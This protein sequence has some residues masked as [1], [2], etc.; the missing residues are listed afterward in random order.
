MGIL[1]KNFG[2]LQ[3]RIKERA[4][5]KGTIFKKDKNEVS[6]EVGNTYKFRL[7]MRAED[8]DSKW[9]W[10]EDLYT[11]EGFIRRLYH[12]AKTPK[13]T[14]KYMQVNC[15]VTYH[16]ARGYKMCPACG[17]LQ[18]LW[19]NDRASYHKFKRK[20]QVYVYVYVLKDPVNPENEGHVKYIYLPVSLYKT[21]RLQIWGLQNPKKDEEPV[22]ID[23]ENLY[24]FDAFKLEK[25]FNLSIQIAEETIEDLQNEGKKKKVRKYTPLWANSRTSVKNVDMTELETEMEA[26]ELGKDFGPATK[27]E[28]QKFYNDVVLGFTPSEKTETSTETTKETKSE[29]KSKDFEVGGDG[30]DLDMG[31]KKESSVAEQVVDEML[32]DSDI[33]DI[34]EDSSNDS[35]DDIDIDDLDDLDDLDDEI[36]DLIGDMD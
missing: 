27:D 14:D 17:V 33:A 25:G 15:P 29:D 31:D 19:K 11:D 20:E 28:L 2:D 34:V 5:N 1:T 7:L 10:H 8:E 12:G 3:K 36:A 35:S 18:D 23:E 30:D 13:P 26:I 6:F 24:G 16:E 22:E 9:N 32:D 4:A 21:L